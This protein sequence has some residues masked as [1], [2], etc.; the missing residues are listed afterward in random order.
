VQDL[1][2][3]GAGETTKSLLEVIRYTIVFEHALGL[4]W[5]SSSISSTCCPQMMMIMY[6]HVLDS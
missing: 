6:A 1:L 4:W 5:S 2:G 3:A